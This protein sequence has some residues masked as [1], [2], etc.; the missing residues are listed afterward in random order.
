M[1]RRV[2]ILGIALLTASVW[3]GFAQ[4]DG[5]SRAQLTRKRY[6]SSATNQEREYF[7]YLPVG[8]DTEKGKKGPVILFLHGGGERGDGLAD[9]EKTLVHGPI[10]E[11]WV[12][13]RD[14]PF[15]LIGPQMPASGAPA[16]PGGPG[17]AAAHVSGGR[18]RTPALGR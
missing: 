5:R 12:K 6:L 7:L 4:V 2:V 11:A 1:K 8:Y 13:G 17:P 10:R 16:P 15:L 3:S 14:L 18:R 9:L